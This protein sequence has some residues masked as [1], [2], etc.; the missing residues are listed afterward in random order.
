MS[1]LHL[2]LLVPAGLLA[3][4]AGLAVGGSR[5]AAW[6]RAELAT[7]ASIVL[8]L[9]SLVVLAVQGPSAAWGLRLDGA[10]AVLALLVGFIGWVIVR[11]SR[12]YLQGEAGERGYLTRLAATLAAVFVVLVADHLLLMAAAWITTS[13]TLHGLLRFFVQRPA[14]RLAAH[15]KF[16]SARLAD[17]SLLG[18]VALL[19]SAY[20][21]LS[22]DTLLARAEAVGVPPLAQAGVALLALTALLK[23]AQMPLHGWV[24]QVMEAPTPVS[25]LLHAGVVNLGGFMLIRFSTLLAEAPGAQALLAAVAAPSVLMAVLVMGTRVSI[26]VHL[27]W[28]TVAQMGF[29]LLQLALG[30]PEMALLHLVA[31]SLYKAHAFLSAGG[32]VARQQVLRLAP[33][34]GA[35]DA[36]SRARWAGAAMLSLA[37]VG[38]VAG[39][40]GTLASPAAWLAGMVLALALVPLVA[41][42]QVL[43]S[44]GVV[45]GWFAGHTL[46]AL[47]ITPSSSSPAPVVLVAAVAAAMALL[48]ALQAAIVLAPRA[49]GVRALHPWAYGGF[50]V[51]ERVSATLLRRW[52][53]PPPPSRGPATRPSGVPA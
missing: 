19:G 32:V 16:L 10:G 9:V 38:A 29:M 31:H 40:S 26:K 14:A 1:S 5:D 27:A 36:P 18:A 11:F 50:Y 4:A 6:Q 53:V 45:L 33:N 23:C 22:L 12:R 34:S 47:L 21:T 20:G 24:I 51:D 46:T 41:A 30:L 15:K 35:A 25:A 44:G 43:R 17:A 7:V 48:F 37:A 8:G 42:G 2:L 28:S 52:P 49:A 39:I 3:L 13:L